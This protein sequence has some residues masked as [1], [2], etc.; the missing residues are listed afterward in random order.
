MV[1]VDHV[2]QQESLVRL[3]TR[4]HD[5]SIVCPDHDVPVPQLNATRVPEDDLGSGRLSKHASDECFGLLLERLGKKREVDGITSVSRRWGIGAVD[6]W[7]PLVALGNSGSCG[8]RVEIGLDLGLVSNDSGRHV[9]MRLRF[10]LLFER[11]YQEL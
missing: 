3:K 11:G 6:G 10:W 4:I 1:Q 9:E 5:G 7:N 8:M 2:D